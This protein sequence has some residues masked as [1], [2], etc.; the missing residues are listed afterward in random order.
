MNAHMSVPGRSVI[1]SFP[2]YRT[3]FPFLWVAHS[4]SLKLLHV[5]VELHLCLN[6]YLWVHFMIFYPLTLT[7]AIAAAGLLR[8]RPW[9]AAALL[10]GGLLGF[11]TDMVEVVLEVAR[12][13]EEVVVVEGGMPPESDD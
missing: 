4:S 1:E 9:V 12:S 10:V 7:F 2:T 8:S 11:F 13:L 5:I 6:S 3:F